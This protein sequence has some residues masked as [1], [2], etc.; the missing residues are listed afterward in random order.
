M[1]RPTFEEIRAETERNALIGPPRPPKIAPKQSAVASRAELE[2]FI[3]ELA[4]DHE[5]QDHD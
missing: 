5:D 1:R 2:R 3:Q 4:H